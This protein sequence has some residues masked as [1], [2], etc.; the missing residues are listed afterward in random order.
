MRRLMF[1]SGV[2]CLLFVVFGLVLGFVPVELWS[3]IIDIF[4]DRPQGVFYKIVP[5]EN[6]GI[7]II[8]LS[9]VGLILILLSRLNLNRSDS[10]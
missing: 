10:N 8:V 1:Y 4:I 7:G 3:F 6:A 5:S 9:A 2:M